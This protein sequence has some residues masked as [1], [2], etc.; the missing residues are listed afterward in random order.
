MRTTLA[1][2]L[3]LL[4]A[5]GVGAAPNAPLPRVFGTY[6][7]WLNGA[8]RYRESNVATFDQLGWPYDRRENTEI[9]ALMA[10]LDRYDLFIPPPLYNYE[11]AQPFEQHIERWRAFLARGGII[12]AVDANYGQMQGWVS[13]LGEGL[14]LHTAQCPDGMKN[15]GA[16]KVAAPADPGVPPADCKVPW[17]HFVDVG[18]GW[19]VLAT[20][21]DGQPICLRADIG[22]GAIIATNLYE[23][24]GYPTAEAVDRLWQAQW[25]KLMAAT[26][27]PAV[28]PGSAGVGHKVVRVTVPAGAGDTVICEQRHGDGPW[29]TET[30]AVRADGQASVLPLTVAAGRSDFRLEVRAGDQR[31]WW[32]SWTES[33]ADLPRRA[34]LVQ[35]EL[36]ATVRT[37]APLPADHPLHAGA[38]QVEQEIQRLTAEATALAA[39][40]SSLTTVERWQAL[41]ARI[42]ALA[43]ASKRL[44]GRAAVAVRAPAQARFAVVRGQ[45]LTK[46]FRDEPPA[47][48]LQGP[49]RVAAARGEGESAQVVIVPL[50]G[51]LSGVQASLAPFVDAAGQELRLDSELHRVCYV[52]T[53]SPTGGADP[54][55]RWWPDPL[56]PADQ[57][58][59]V[60][61]LCQ[62]LWI[63][64]W[65]PR[66]AKAGVYT[67]SLV[68]SAAGQTER[69]PIE[70]RILDFSLPEEHGLRQVFAFRAPQITQR[71]R[72]AADYKQATPVDTYLR[73]M[74]VCLK[75]R[76][77]VQAFGWE[78]NPE[79][80]SLMA[81]MGETKADDGW[82]FDFT[83]ADRIWSRQYRAGMRT[84]F[85]GNT[86]GC[87]TLAG[88][89][90]KEAYWT[91]LE[92]YLRALVPHLKERGWYD[93]AVW[94][95][96]DEGWQDDAVQANLRL[97]ALLDREAP[98][99][100]RLMTAPRDPRLFG[101]S[102]IWVPGGLPEAHPGEKSSET[103]LAGWANSGAER[104]WYIC[105]GP[106]HPYP[107]FFVDYPTID[108]RMVF[109]LSWKYDKTGFLYWGVEYFGDPAKMT[110]DG[111]TEAYPMGPANMGN[112]DGTLCY[113]GPD[114]AFYPSIR[115]NANRDGI[116]D[117]ECFKMLRQLADEA[118]KAGLAPTLT[119]RARRLLMVDER[120]LKRTDGSPNFSYTLEPRLLTDARGEL[121]EVIVA[122]RGALGR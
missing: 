52:H 122:L 69:V 56:L 63:D 38:Q 53:E 92:A 11:H 58:F 26:A 45:P 20:C 60:T 95:M 13:Q 102:S 18:P 94:Y 57:P 48:P 9:A 108:Q 33:P 112:G 86:P 117:Y 44:A 65:A 89:A 23:D 76:V 5:V 12:V 39:G 30:L 35:A 27:R 8:H 110:T 68:V 50:Q 29:Q 59:A 104:W 99:L 14:G 82:H 118:E 19:K 41:G 111:P 79:P 31:R 119:A 36:A 2:W 107:N 25:P 46:V 24:A 87:G 113:W 4:F 28:E 37:I 116:E 97:A 84:L 85:V 16:I 49:V 70:L 47:G 51:D 42:D 15:Q 66:D 72:G 77:G 17:A 6:S 34:A 90:A 10:D 106:Q 75:R 67:G 100:K 71:Y 21:P 61:Q 114:E 115:L 40:E 120:V 1:P 88:A 121:N 55:P 22:R 73:M 91:F 62:P 81:Y 64:L 101:K 7:S 3:A 96:V 43:P 93:A 103:A 74:E 105:C 109:W 78:G 83:Q 32:T 98:G 80:S 54:G